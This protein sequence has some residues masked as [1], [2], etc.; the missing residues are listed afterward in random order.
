[1]E[2][3]AIIWTVIGFGMLSLVSLIVWQF[4]NLSENQ[5]EMINTIQEINI[6]LAGDDAAET[7]LR[8][9]NEKTHRK[10]EESIANLADSMDTMAKNI[11]SNYFTLKEHAIRMLN[12]EAKQE[13]IAEEVRQ[14]RA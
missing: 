8:T 2:A 13:I 1:M 9:Q 14:L 3:E 7:I 10:M 5:K 4:K 11:N 6:K 12:L